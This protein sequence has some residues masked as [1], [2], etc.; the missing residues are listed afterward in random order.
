MGPKATKAWKDREEETQLEAG[1]MMVGY[2]GGMH[3]SSTATV[4]MQAI[5][6][7]E[8]D[9]RVSGINTKTLSLF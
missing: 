3:G 2:N 6:A 4:C 7:P 5:E 1:G 9:S 8:A